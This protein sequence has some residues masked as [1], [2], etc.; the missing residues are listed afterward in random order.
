VNKAA[1]Q[2]PQE[3][4]FSDSPNFFSFLPHASE[5]MSSPSSLLERPPSR[6]YCMYNYNF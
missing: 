4:G 5:G 2:F 1:S 6:T 3:A